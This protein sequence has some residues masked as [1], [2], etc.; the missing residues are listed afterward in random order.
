MEENRQFIVEKMEE[1]DRQLQAFDAVLELAVNGA[2]GY[3]NGDMIKSL[4]THVRGVLTD[5]RAELD[6]VTGALLVDK[7]LRALI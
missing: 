6:E 1:I 5:M 7:P 3:G 2:D 4:A